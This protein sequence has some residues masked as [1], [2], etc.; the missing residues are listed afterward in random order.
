MWYCSTSCLSPTL[1]NPWLSN[2]PQFARLKN[3]LFANCEVFADT[4][5][6]LPGATMADKV[7]AHCAL[8]GSGQSVTQSKY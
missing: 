5:E 2:A 8:G 6:K 3:R 7:I 1:S 4:E